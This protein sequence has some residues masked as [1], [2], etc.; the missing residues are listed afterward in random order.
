VR[1]NSKDI[2]TIL[3]TD[4]TTM[5]LRGQEEANIIIKIL[6]IYNAILGALIN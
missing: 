6:K 1:I 3:F 5:I 4:D 2:K